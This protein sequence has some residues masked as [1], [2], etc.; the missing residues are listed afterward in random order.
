MSTP[1]IVTDNSEM[2]C[3]DWTGTEAEVSNCPMA[4]KWHEGETEFCDVC[5][6]GITYMANCTHENT[7]QKVRFGRTLIKC[8]DCRKI[9]SIN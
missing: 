5:G 8:K 2:P 4:E 7:Y 1:I 3:E 6:W 9:L